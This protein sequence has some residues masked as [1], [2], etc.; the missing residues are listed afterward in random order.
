MIV[1][2]FLQIFFLNNY[3]QA[4]KISETTKMASVIA[5]QYGQEDFINTIRSISFTNDLYIHIETSD[6]TIAVSYTHLRAHE[7]RH[8]LVCRLL[9]EKKKKKKTTEKYK[10]LLT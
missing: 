10:F 1:L 8:D 2:W 5:S 6:G 4:M 9:L 7:T 3:Y